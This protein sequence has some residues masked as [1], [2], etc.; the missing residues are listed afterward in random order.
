MYEGFDKDFQ[1]VT[2]S[3]LLCALFMSVII[4]VCCIKTYRDE[5]DSLKMQVAELSRRQDSIEEWYAENKTV[6]QTYRFFNESWKAIIDL[7][8]GEQ[9]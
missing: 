5:V 2:I 4:S 3:A 1:Y 8:R 6:M 7:K 9:E